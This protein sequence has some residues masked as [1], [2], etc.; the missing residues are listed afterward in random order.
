M[1]LP[2]QGLPPVPCALCLLDCALILLHVLRHK[3]ACL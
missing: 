1:L 2:S 3:D